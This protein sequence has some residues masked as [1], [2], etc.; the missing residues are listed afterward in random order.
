VV[1]LALLE[2][3]LG[4][5]D[6]V[7]LL[8][9]LVDAVALVLALG[10]LDA[11]ALGLALVVAVAVALPVGEELDGGGEELGAC[12]VIVAVPLGSVGEPS[13]VSLSFL[14]AH[15]STFVVP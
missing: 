1:G 7:A 8:V 12:H 13:F 9:A 4:L 5:L 11:V 15:A 10:L 14:S 3:A 2:L 6:A